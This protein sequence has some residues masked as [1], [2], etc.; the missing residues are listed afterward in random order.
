MP[1]PVE[2]IDQSNAPYVIVSSD[3]H[4]GLY[5]E[6]YRPY[7]ESSVHAEFDEWLATRHQHRAMVEELNGEYVERWE[8]R[9]RGRAQGRLR[10]RHP[11]QDAR[12][13]RRGRRG[14]LRRRR[15]GHRH[16][17]AAVRRRAAGGHD[18]RPAPRLGR[19]PGP[20]PLARG[21]LRHQPA[22]PRRRRARARSPTAS[23]SRSREIEA[24]AGK[25]G[26]KGI[27]IP[28]MWHDQ[29]SYG[30]ASYDP[31]W[32]ACAE[33]GLVVHTHSGEADT[34]GLQRQ[35]GAVHARG[36]VLDPPAAVAAAAVGGVRPLSRT[37]ST[38][39]SSAGRGGSATSCSRPT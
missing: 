2:G 29:P 4:A 34:A 15:L 38:R 11:R 27:M 21:V 6:D 23:T 17:G 1:N 36:G 25:P 24:L 26:I 37:S 10:P 33:A 8:Q 18:H 20:Q 19:G 39:R 12:R 13:R 30:H 9:Q 28:T 5:V 31:V 3:T 16:G 35:H 22:P 32:A 7:L 14:D